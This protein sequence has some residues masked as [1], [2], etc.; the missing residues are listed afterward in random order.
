MSGHLRGGGVK[1]TKELSSKDLQC[2]G[3]GAG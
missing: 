1:A 2:G 3:E